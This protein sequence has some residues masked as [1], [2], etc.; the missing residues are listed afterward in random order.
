MKLI[1]LEWE[2]AVSRNNWEETNDALEWAKKR[3]ALVRDV[4]WVLHEDKKQITLA[5]RW[6]PE[7]DVFDTEA[8]GLLQ[9]IPKTWIR[10]RVDLT[11]YI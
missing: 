1:Y 8:F 5:A 4:G 9:K 10:K 7:D 2:D 6:Q 3:C 11:Q